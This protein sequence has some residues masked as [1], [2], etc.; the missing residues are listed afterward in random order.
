MDPKIEE[1]TQQLTPK[2]TPKVGSSQV[3]L[4]FRSAAPSTRAKVQ[5]Q[6]GGRRPKAPP[7]PSQDAPR[8]P[9]PFL[10]PPGTPQGPPRTPNSCSGRCPFASSART[11]RQKL[12]IGED[13]SCWIPISRSDLKPK[14]AQRRA[15]SRGLGRKLAKLE[16]PSLGSAMGAL[17]FFPSLL[18]CNHALQL[19]VRAATES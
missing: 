11:F 7:G 5:I 2:W 12:A 4:E 14:T 19:S 15:R 9:P 17:G 13:N 18:V 16:A 8:D 10:V 3:A 1:K 6:S